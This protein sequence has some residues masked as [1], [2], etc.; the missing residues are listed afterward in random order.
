MIEGDERRPWPGR[1]SWA[2]TNSS[3][4]MTRKDFGIV[5]RL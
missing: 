4:A 2:V 5:T 1:S 3:A